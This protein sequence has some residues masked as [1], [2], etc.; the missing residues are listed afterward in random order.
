[1]CFFFYISR[2]P[3]LEWLPGYSFDTLIKD[4]I[5]GLTVGLTAIPQGIAYAVV[6]GLPPQVPMQ[7]YYKLTMSSI[8]FSESRVT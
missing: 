2:L 7:S 8:N 1:M 6:A 4:L 5:A 3:I